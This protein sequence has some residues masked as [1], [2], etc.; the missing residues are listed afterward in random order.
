MGTGGATALADALALARVLRAVTVCS[1]DGGAGVA[2]GWAGAAFAR[3][4][5]GARA[6]SMLFVVEALSALTAA[7][8]EAMN[9]FCQFFGT[10]LRPR[11]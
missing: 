10:L 4:T 5:G 6:T 8:P 3:M 9:F 7:L 2:V 1:T 11:T